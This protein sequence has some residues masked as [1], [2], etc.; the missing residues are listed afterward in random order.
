MEAGILF[1]MKFISSSLF[2]L[3]M[4]RSNFF[5]SSVLLCLPLTYDMFSLN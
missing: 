2:I 1:L 3:Y 4:Y 5:R